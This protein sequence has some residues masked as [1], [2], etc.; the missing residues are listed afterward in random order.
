M[1]S[2]TSASSSRPIDP[3]SP[4]ASQVAGAI[5]TGTTRSGRYEKVAVGGSRPQKPLSA[6]SRLLGR[7]G[8][9]VAGPSGSGSGS[10]PRSNRRNQTTPSSQPPIQSQTQPTDIISPTVDDKVRNLSLAGSTSSDSSQCPSSYPSEDDDVLANAEILQGEEDYDSDEDVWSPSHGPPNDSEEPR[11]LNEIDE[12]EDELSTIFMTSS[13]RRHSRQS[14]FS[15][16]SPYISVNASRTHGHTPTHVLSRTNNNYNHSNNKPSININTGT[17]NS[18]N[19]STS[20]MTSAPIGYMAKFSLGTPTTSHAAHSGPSSAASS[21]H[22]GSLSGHGSHTT[23][24]T[25]ATSEQKRWSQKGAIVSLT[26]NAK[27]ITDTTPITKNF[28]GPTHGNSQSI[29]RSN[30]VLQ[31]ESRFVVNIP[32]SPNT[33][34]GNGFNNGGGNAYSVSSTGTRPRRTSSS[35]FS[36]SKP[37]TSGYL[38]TQSYSNSGS[39]TTEL[40]RFFQKPWRTSM[41]SNIPGSL[42]DSVGGAPESIE[43]TDTM[44]GSYTSNASHASLASNNNFNNNNP[45]NSPTSP[46]MSRSWGRGLARSFKSSTSL[47]KIGGKAEGSVPNGNGF[48][49]GLMLDARN[50]SSLSKTYG[51]LG[52]SLGGGAGGNVRLVTRQTDRKVFAVK[53]YRQKQSFETM[54]EY[55]RKV[56]AEYCI[57]L[58]LQHPNII[59]TVDIIYESDRVFQIMEY[60]EYDLFAIVMSGKMTQNEIFCDFKQIMAGV[61]YMH[62]AGLAHRDLKL[63]NCV[64]NAAG[65]VKIIDFGGASV[66]KYPGESDRIHDAVG[67]VG[68][69]PY[70]APEMLIH[71]SYDPR[72]TDI[73]SCAIVFCCMLMRKFPWKIPKASDSSFKVFAGDALENGILDNSRHFG[74]A[75]DIGGPGSPGSERLVRSLP[76]D[77]RRLVANMLHLVPH[78]RA[79]VEQVWQDEW[80]QAVEMCSPDHHCL[81]HDHTSVASDE[82]HIASLEKKNR[83]RKPG[84]KMW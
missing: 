64:V 38:S 30:S 57:G 10:S 76:S 60:C 52:K 36:R 26:P 58:T 55:S 72:P 35:L 4:L 20:T 11:G 51:K 74:A 84:E 12:D 23:G 67:I 27:P 82:A 32:G 50:K 66:F 47:S 70:L 5:E 34:N 41:N 42:S 81:N 3:T 39:S 62:E 9:K 65:I 1:S 6:L 61:K 24:T 37:D 13:S 48:G 2:S 46:M 7:A 73:W 63:D 56:T 31:V 80:L 77:V 83:K 43:D 71:R 21:Y 53:E 16:D 18:N 79:S 25:P 22:D 69:D 15:R 29:G 8:S 17:V 45:S 59:E 33:G 78:K 14:S 75:G 28:Y 54:R 40:K 49:N 68:S 44:V 19:T